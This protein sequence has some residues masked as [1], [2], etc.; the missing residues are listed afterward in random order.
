MEMRM[1][2][3]PH[4]DDAVF[5]C[6]GII[7]EQSLRGDE[8]V[9]VT[10]CAR[11]PKGSF[12]SKYVQ[13]F[14][15]RWG[16]GESAMAIRK[17]EDRRACSLMGARVLHLPILDA[18]YRTNDEGEHYYAS[19]EA[20]FGE[21]HPEEVD[22]IGEIAQLLAAE[23]ANASEIYAPAGYGGHV[24]HRLTRKAVDRL[25]RDYWL[26]RDFPYA[27]RGGK[28]PPDL[29]TPEVAERLVHLNQ[30]EMAQWAEAVLEYRSQLSTFWSDPSKVEDELRSFHDHLG[31]VPFLPVNRKA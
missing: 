2:I 10:V 4:L 11:T 19:D 27:A 14:H 23:C 29:R 12:S 31:G 8:I 18:I 6:G 28:L 13:E 25:G 1:Y 16:T 30:D 17:E 26:Y 24:D 22:L 21:I 3:S 7:Y 9:V 15:K 20:I 5:S